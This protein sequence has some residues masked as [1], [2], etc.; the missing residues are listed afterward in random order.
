MKVV[1]ILNEASGTLSVP[2]N[3]DTL[4]QAL[5]NT[6][7]DATALTIT[8]GDEIEPVLRP[9][10]E[11]GCQ[12]VIAAGGD[13]TVNAVATMLVGTSV[14]LGVIPGGTLNHFA[15]DLHIPEDLVE[16]VHVLK[17][18]TTQLVDVGTV[19]GRLFLNNSGLGLYPEMVMKREEIR[20][21]GF[22]K[23]TALLMA[24]ALTLLRFPLLG[25]RLEGNGPAIE[26]FT[27]FVFVGNNLYEVD[28]LQF[29]MRSCIDEGALCVWV[30]HSTSRF[31]LL[32]AVFQMAFQGL[33]G[34]RELDV[35]TTHE[36]VIRSRRKFVPVS[37]DGE[38]FHLR[39][40]LH[41]EMRPGALRVIVPSTGKVE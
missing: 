30:A 21:K 31:G 23:A 13:G 12:V 11:S 24:S 34:V 6:G 10:I 37:L 27:P 8:N 19:N 15:R 18:G 3:R 9:H 36:L 16:A 38:V 17:E 29:G 40:P 25:V 1:L 32:R 4:L 2:G 41:Y 35:L 7:L 26:R 28:G 39:T 20:K 33:G 14:R 22:R 5:I